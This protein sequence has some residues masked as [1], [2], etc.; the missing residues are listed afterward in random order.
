MRS[1]KLEKDGGREIREIRVGERKGGDGYVH[2]AR[3]PNRMLKYSSHVSGDATTRC[4][5][6][7]T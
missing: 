6:M 2:T 7:R 4:D 5:A 3:Q 1:D